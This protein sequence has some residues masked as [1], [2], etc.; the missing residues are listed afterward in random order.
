MTEV[1]AYSVNDVL[2]HEDLPDVPGGES[3]KASLNF[4]PLED[5]KE[6]SRQRNTSGGSA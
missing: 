2:M 3:R 1:G 4:V 6:L 5:W